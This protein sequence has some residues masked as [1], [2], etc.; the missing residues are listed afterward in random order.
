M[1]QKLKDLMLPFILM[2]FVSGVV[3]LPAVIGLTYATGSQRPDHSLTYEAG[4]LVWDKG[5]YVRS[6]GSAMLSF[7]D[8]T[9]SNVAG[10]S[11][12]KLIAPGTEKKTSVRL[13]N[14]TNQ[15]I[16]YTAVLYLVSTSPNLSIDASFLMGGG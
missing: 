3:M 11:S 8:T 7:F 15:E 10:E 14:K 16:S 12:D 5:T 13:L 4:A 1:K 9:H 2:L 6:D